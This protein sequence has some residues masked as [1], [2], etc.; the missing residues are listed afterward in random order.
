MTGSPE[1]A[2]RLRYGADSAYGVPGEWS[3][4]LE[5]QLAHR[6]V[7]SYRADPVS[8]ET[9]AALIAAAQSAP[10][11]GNLQLWSVV[12][13]R[14]DERRARLAELAGDQEFIVEAPLLL[15]WLAD[16]AGP[17]RWPAFGTTAEGA[18]FVEA[19]LLSFID[20]ALA[21]QNASLAAESLGLGTVFVGAIRNRP[22]EVAAELGLPAE[23]VPGLRPDGRPPR[24]LDETAVKPRLPQA[25]SCITS[26]TTSSPRLPCRDLRGTPQRLLRHSRSPQQLDQPS[27]PPLRHRR[28]SEGSRAPPRRPPDP[29]LRTPLG[30]WFPRILPQYE[31]SADRAESAD[32]VDDSLSAPA[33]GAWTSRRKQS[34]PVNRYVAV[35]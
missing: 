14:D 27:S 12:A 23:R 25:R 20:V 22:L 34:S 18:D 35:T 2:Y 26:A 13:V 29:R 10:T 28:G 11:S 24:S 6:S 33:S 7:R 1:V 19:A 16:L 32:R 5:R 8:E 30:Q 15:V 21:A 4:V 9:L 17:G 3:E 31:R